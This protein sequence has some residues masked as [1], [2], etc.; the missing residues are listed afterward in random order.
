M[1]R[2]KIV[3]HQIRLFPIGEYG[4]HQGGDDTDSLNLLDPD[5]DPWESVMKN[6]ARAMVRGGF[7]FRTSGDP[8]V[9]E[10]G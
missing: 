5:V 8:D 1:A 9:D 10:G 4:G 7:R 2:K 6:F 3:D